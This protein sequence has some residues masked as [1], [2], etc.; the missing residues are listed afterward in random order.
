MHVFLPPLHR[1][2]F[3]QRPPPFLKYLQSIL[4]KY[5][6]GGQ[7]LKELIQNAD[8]AGATEVIFLCDER[9]YG[10]Q[11]LAVEGLQ[12]AQGPALV[13]YNDGLFSEA[14]WDGIQSTGDSH[15]LRD[16]GT[17]GSFGLGFNSV[18]HLTD[19]PAVLSGPWLGVLDPQRA[20]LADGGQQ[21]HLEERAELA[22]QFAPFWGALEVMGCGTGCPAAGR[23]PGTLFRFPLRHEPSGISDNLYSP[24]RVRQLFLAFIND[25]SICLLFL[26]HVRRLALKMVDGQ[27]ATTELLEITAAPRPL[28]GPGSVQ[29]DV[30][31]AVLAT[32]ACIKAV[33]AHGMATDGDTEREWLVVSAVPTEGAFP[34]LAELAGALG[35][36]PGMALAYPLR[37]G[38][39]GHLCCFL[40]LPATEEN[41][42]GLPLH[43]NVPFHLTDDRRHVQWAEEDR[44]RD[45]AARW[46]QLLTEAVLPLAYRQAVV[47]A[48]AACPSDPYGTW[49][50]PELSQHQQRYQSLA[51]RICQQ[52]W[53]MEALVPAGQPGTR[54]LRA[55]DAV[56]LPQ[57]GAGE[58][59]LRVLE[60][61]LVQAGEPLATVPAHVRRALAAGGPAV[62]EA[63]PAYMRKVLGRV[64]PAQYPAD[65]RLLLE[66]V[67]GDK[68]YGELAGLELLPR[69]DGGFVCFGGAGGTVYADSKAFPRILLPGLA[70]SFLPEDLTPALL[71][72]LQRIAEQGKWEPSILRY[73]SL[74]GVPGAA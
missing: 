43:L 14:D 10:T 33:V 72:H 70:D 1:R 22:D 15:K 63:T 24:E 21:W 31:A 37:G 68:R 47:V 73:P 26:R 39:A 36:L 69:A 5:P 58:A 11:S 51:E 62:K 17:V 48:A 8:D 67:V 38:C 56:F 53:G 50:D 74:P 27:G 55:M 65:K 6:D 54:R 45:H 66:Y 44:G 13:A 12:R 59:T 30:A 23:F 42:T 16:P 18:Y 52:L 40:P 3:R 71:S 60:D 20:A 41:T 25:A 7:I 64:G 4:R 35:S 2:G 46:N 19:L 32:T 49:P 29:D 57:N 28:N 34:E 9:C 61:A